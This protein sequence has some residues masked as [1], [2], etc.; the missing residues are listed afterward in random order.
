MKQ[1]YKFTEN[2]PSNAGYAN[3]EFFTEGTIVF[4]E[5]SF[6][7]KYCILCDE[8]GYPME[9]EDGE[10]IFLD[11]RPEFGDAP[12]WETILEPYKEVEMVD[13][14]VQM[15]IIP[16]SIGKYTLMDMLDAL[17]EDS[18]V[19]LDVDN[20]IKADLTQQF[21]E[22]SVVIILEKENF[23][24]IATNIQVSQE[25]LLSNDNVEDLFSSIDKIKPITVNFKNNEEGT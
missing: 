16:A 24:L 22:D 14:C 9:D 2:L 5:S 20:K 8:D 13:N 15:S 18:N 10:E 17:P 12:V 1:S 7:Y 23:A 3:F 4:L 21:G 25:D 11:W 6:P 19:Y